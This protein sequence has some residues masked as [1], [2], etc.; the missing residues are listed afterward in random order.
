MPVA[1]AFKKA[2]MLF[3]RFLSLAKGRPKNT[4]KPAKAPRATISGVDMLRLISLG[5]VPLHQE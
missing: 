3:G 4:V 1:Q 5:N 2:C